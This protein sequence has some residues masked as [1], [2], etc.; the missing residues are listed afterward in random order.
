[1]GKRTPLILVLAIALVVSIGLM[2]SLND[3]SGHASRT[4]GGGSG[5]GDSASALETGAGSA[6]SNAEYDKRFAELAAIHGQSGATGRV[7][8]TRPEAPGKDLKV[9][10]R[11]EVEGFVA[12][13]EAK[14][15]GQGN[16]TF[17]KLLRIDG[18]ELTITG[19][20]V[21]DYRK[22]GLN[23]SG[24][25]IEADTGNINAG[26]HRVDR[27]Y[28]VRGRVV[29]RGGAGVPDANVALVMPLGNRTFSWFEM[30]EKMGEADPTIAE[31]STPGGGRFEFRLKEPGRYALRVRAKGWATRFLS[32]I[33]VGTGLD[34]EYTV[35]LVEGYPVAGYVLD[36]AGRPVADAVV[37]AVTSNWRSWSFPKELWKTDGTG[38]FEFRMPPSSGRGYSLNVVPPG[39]AI[40]SRQFRV[41]LEEELII[42]LPSDATLVGRIIDRETKDPIAGAAILVNVAKDRSNMWRPDA[43]MALMTDEYGVFKI[44]GLEPGNI[45][46]ISI[47]AEGYADFAAHAMWA[48]DKK[49]SDAI[50]KIKVKETGETKLPDITLSRGNVLTGRVLDAVSLDPIPGARIEVADWV[51]GSRSMQTGPDG[52]YRFENL[53]SRISLNAEAVGYADHRDSFMGVPLEPKNGAA[54]R[55]I[56]L[57]PGASLSGT[58]KTKEGTP[59]KSALVRLKAKASGWGSWQQDLSLRN[60]WANTDDVGRWSISGIPGFKLYV[61]AEAKGYDLGKSGDFELEPGQE[62]TADIQ[63]QESASLEGFVKSR[64]G[65]PVSGARVTVARDPGEGD[66]WSQ[67]RALADGLTTFTDVDGRFSVKDVPTG[68]VLVRIEADQFATLTK[69][70]PDVKPAQAIKREEMTLSPAKTIIGRVVNEK[71]VPFTQG[72]LRAKHTASPEGEPVTQLMS[73]RIERDG[74]FV[75]RN[76]PEGTYSIE[77]RVNNRM[78]GF[79][80]YRNTTQEGVIA[81]SE[82]V[83]IRLTPA[84]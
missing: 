13:A 45:Q 57:R 35:A 28:F 80:N 71:G 81:G 20:A 65:G 12:E 76:L 62:K 53:G 77:V 25:Q 6:M 55:E 5:N 22:D 78:P 58:V 82:N 1:M 21:Q 72:W 50:R 73:G 46:S 42:Q 7:L 29:G 24:E 47:R 4:E 27:W 19:K 41:P 15:D 64:D 48:T 39:G 70:Y 3:E 9:S 37:A 17:P 60:L 23:F 49:V 33:E 56:E 36:A 59:I 8:L 14:T 38:R 75:L 79:E 2:L 51:F 34:K 84:E 26:I 43:R 18:Y 52:S 11:A 32:R 83:E 67:W 68:K 69:R 74:T 30:A 44:K 10:I 31:M 66:T 40:V 54:R 63:M 61:E 16:F